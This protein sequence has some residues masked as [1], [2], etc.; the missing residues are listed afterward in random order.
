MFLINAY[1]PPRAF[2][3][4]TGEF[5][6]VG[7]GEHCDIR[8]D[9]PSVS[10]VH[11]RVLARDGSVMLTDAGSR[12]GTFVNGERV[13]EAELRSGDRVRVGETVLTVS[14]EATSHAT[15]IA[16]AISDS[17]I[18]DPAIAGSAIVETPQ[19]SLL[20]AATENSPEF[21][22]AVDGRERLAQ[23]EWPVRQP[24]MDLQP[25]VPAR[26]VGK[27]FLRY[28]IKSLISHSRSGLSL[29][30]I[31]PALKRSV[32]IKIYRPDLLQSEDAVA[33]FLR[34][35]RTMINFRHPNIVRLFDAG[36]HDGFCY[37]ITEHIDGVTAAQLIKNFGVAGMLDW[38]TTVRI[39]LDLCAA[40]EELHEQGVVHRDV[41]PSHIVIAN[42]DR[43]A[44]ISEVVLAKPWDSEQ[45]E[46]LTAAGD[47][48][49]DLTWQSPEQLGNGEPIDHRTDIYQLGLTLYSLLVGS[50]PFEKKS[51][52]SLVQSILGDQPRSPKSIQ[53]AIPD[54]LS[55]TI[56]RA[57][58][59]RPADRQQ[60]AN[61]VAEELQRV[62][63]FSA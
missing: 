48:I 32:V 44:A 8:L 50:P 25:F 26:F 42:D 57:L 12:W 4:H 51:A 60:S 1:E 9:D 15:T 54:L 35:V 10:R 21:D 47:V 46:Q 59:K 34:A 24:V 52:A 27:E 29:L 20:H 41:R 5:V 23:R 49:G 33:R 16:P 30:A 14:P 45:L 56:L 55:D 28:E 11:C 2:D 31:D 58:S 63:K 38:R 40:L 39:G 7:R 36:A 43:H 18:A 17:A 22:V 19:Q 6:L 37:T 53:L 61:A 3:L 13:E 62:L